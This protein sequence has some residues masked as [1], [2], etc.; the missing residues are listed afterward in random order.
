M[1]RIVLI[2]RVAQSTVAASIAEACKSLNIPHK[3]S[4]VSSP[5]DIAYLRFKPGDIVFLYGTFHQTLAKELG[6][7]L[8]NNTDITLVNKKRYDIGFEDKYIQ[9][10][11]LRKF[12]SKYYI[13]TYIANT[14][15]Q[16]SPICEEIGFP[17]IAKE[18]HSF[19]GQGVH[20][21]K[22]KTDI[23]SILPIFR[24]VIFQPFIP[25][26]GDYRIVC[27]GNVSVFCAKRTAAKGSITNNVASGG[28]GTLEIPE[29]T[30]SKLIKA[31]LSIHKKTELDIS[32][33]DMVIDKNTGQMKV[34]EINSLQ[35]VFKVASYYGIPVAEQFVTY[36]IAK[37]GTS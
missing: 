26:E 16:I 34:F 29:P 24:R 11:F 10:K 32:G 6:E 23:G 25:N 36:L 31:A 19:G 21:L 35:P 28:T 37:Y 1:S 15:S 30:R 7:M 5:K 20:L 8:R 33:I 14:E 12:A 18:T 9:S 27:I 17:C 2:G 22:K 13:P 4:Q 3:Y